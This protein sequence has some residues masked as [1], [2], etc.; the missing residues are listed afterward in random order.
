MTSA[1]APGPNP[2]PAAAGGRPLMVVDGNSLLHRS[3]HA[4][5]ASGAR[6]S[7]GQPIW[8]IRGL[9]TQLVAAADRIGPARIVVGFD[10]PDASTRRERWPDYKAQRVDKLP[11]LVAQLARA[12]EVLTE[13]GVQVVTPPGHE[14]DDVLA[15]A[16]RWNARHRGRTVLVTSDRDAFAL[17]DADTSVLRVING[18]V[19]ASPLLTPDRLELML[20]ITPAQYADFAALR[21]DPSDNLPGVRGVGPKRAAALLKRFGSADALFADADAGGRAIADVVGPGCRARLCEADARA[22]WRRNRAVMRMRDDLPVG[23]HD[24]D[25]GRLPL[26]A[27]AVRRT[28][29]AHDLPATAT[30]AARALAG[31]DDATPEQPGVLDAL[32]WDASAQWRTRRQLPPLPE[33]L[34]PTLF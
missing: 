3:F 4:L 6:D 2:V 31:A 1:T 33:R 26:P 28:L 11:T 17:I 13:L 7:L 34:Q 12:A 27:R 15:S 5:A 22:A 29:L 10:D 20:G 32:G 14:A 9:L 30:L 8:A 18:G 23:L 24:P 16:A 19:E 25:A 21:G